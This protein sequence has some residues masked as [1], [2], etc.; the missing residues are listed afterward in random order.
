M[1]LEYAQKVLAGKEL[2]KKEA[3]EL[4]NVSDDDTMLL[5]AMADKIRQKFNGNEV[6]CCA[7][8]NARSGHC[9]ENCKF[10]AQSAY[11]KT[12]VDVYGLLDEEELVQ[13][14]KKAKEAGVSSVVFDRNGFVYHGRIKALADSA[15]EAGLKF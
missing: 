11:S 5:L 14:A 10:C 12:G 9:P 6:D 4:I 8:V 13:A 15:R 2:T 1:I 7:I 3:V